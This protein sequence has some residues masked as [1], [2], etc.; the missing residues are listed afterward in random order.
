M[1]MVFIEQPLAAAGSEKSAFK[2]KLLYVK[3]WSQSQGIET[4]IH[5][6]KQTHTQTNTQKMPIQNER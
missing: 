4:N 6:S 3:H 5:A 2:I 1:T